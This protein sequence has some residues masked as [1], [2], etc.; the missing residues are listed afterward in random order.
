MVILD[1]VELLKIV[2]RESRWDNQIEKINISLGCF[3]LLFGRWIDLI[4]KNWALFV[5]VFYAEIVNDH[6]L[7]RKELGSLPFSVFYSAFAHFADFF[8]KFRDVLHEK[9]DLVH[10]NSNRS[11]C[12]AVFALR[13]VFATENILDDLVVDVA[14]FSVKLLNRRTIEM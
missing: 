6:S 7:K 10:R 4:N 1:T 11:R 12:Y 8:A 5:V 14:N 2:P 3:E 9:L 13:N